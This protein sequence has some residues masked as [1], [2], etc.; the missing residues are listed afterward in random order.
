MTILETILSIALIISV[1][2]SIGYIKNLKSIYEEDTRSFMMDKALLKEKVESL[3][4]EKI[5]ISTELENYKRQYEVYKE[6]CKSLNRKIVELKSKNKNGKE[7][8]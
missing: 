3:E 1:F 6:N 5:L 4:E 7:N 2:Y 8:K